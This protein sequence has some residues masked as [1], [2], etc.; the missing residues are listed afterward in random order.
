MPFF[1]LVF[2]LF[3]FILFANVMGL[4][5]VYGFT[6]TSHLIITVAMALLVFLRSLLLVCGNTGC[7]FSDYLSPAVFRAT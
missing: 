1:P 7:I 4:I 5:P 2:S 3:M 6:V